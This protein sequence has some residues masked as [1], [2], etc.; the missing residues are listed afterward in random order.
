MEV[1]FEEE[2]KIWGKGY[3]IVAGIDEAG[4]GPLA[5]PVVAAAVAVLN[6]YPVG[7][8]KKSKPR[9]FSEELFFKRYNLFSIRDSKKLSLKKREEFFKVLRNIPEI[10]W[11]IGRVSERVIDRINIL[12][13][14][15]LAMKKAAADLK[16]KI[17]K[18]RNFEK[19]NAIDFLIIDGNVGFNS[20]IS[21]KLIIKADEKVFSCVAA[22][23]IAKVDRDRIMS[24]HHKKYPEYGFN[25]H[26]G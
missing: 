16:G 17:K 3:K 15:R 7:E 12:E 18:R 14:T 25:R 26:K 20:P 9:K 24:R 4:R 13:A 5:G 8:N 23:I 2:K 19:V 6:Q 1:S 21:Q 10:E 11:G 22:G